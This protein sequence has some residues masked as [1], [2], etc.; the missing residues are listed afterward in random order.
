[1]ALDDAFFTAFAADLGSEQLWPK[2]WEKRGRDGP[3]PP[4]PRVDA[5]AMFWEMMRVSRA[6]DPCMWP[7]VRALRREAAAEGGELVLGALS[8]TVVFPEGVRDERGVVF[9]SGLSG[10]GEAGGDIKDAFDV[11]VSSAHVGLRK[12]DPEIYRMAV[13]LMDEVARKRGVEGGIEAGDVLF[14]D[15]IGQNLKA[16]REL[17]MR[18]LKVELGRSWKAVRELEQIM[19]LKLLE[20]EVAR[21]KARL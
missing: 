9:E 14:L 18:T 15:D 17:G 4:P 5:R 12:P 11:F 8:N 7:A 3:P 10:E 19:G 13:R 21:E 20:G 6:P 1:M 16:A 2:F